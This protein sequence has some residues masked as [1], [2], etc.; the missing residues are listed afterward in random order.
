MRMAAKR[1]FQSHKH[2]WMEITRNQEELKKLRNV[3]GAIK[4]KQEE[5]VDITK[6]TPQQ[7]KNFIRKE[8]RIWKCIRCGQ[9]LF[10]DDEPDEDGVA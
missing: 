1:V 10:A 6:I 8:T 9:V 2:Q 4:R 5:G 7:T 3:V